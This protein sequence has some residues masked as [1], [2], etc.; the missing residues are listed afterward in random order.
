MPSMVEGA[1]APAVSYSL[2]H[3]LDR[4]SFRQETEIITFSDLNFLNGS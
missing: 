1:G 4:G 2:I 3:A